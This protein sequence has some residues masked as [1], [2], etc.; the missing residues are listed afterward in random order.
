VEAVYRLVAVAYAPACEA[1]LKVVYVSLVVFVPVGN[2]NE[3][4]WGAEKEAVETHGDGC[5]KGYSLQEY[6]AR[7]GFS[8]VIGILENE[9][10]AL[11]GV[12]ESLPAG[13]IV[14]VFGDPQ[15]A[16]VIPAK[17]HRLC[18]HGF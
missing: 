4:R 9:Y 7:V 10:A 8:V 12:G 15:A 2:K 17:G 18:H 16:T 1:D 14:F 6:F 5:G 3:V 13:F 11:P